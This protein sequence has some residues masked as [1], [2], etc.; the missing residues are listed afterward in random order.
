MNDKIIAVIKREFGRHF[1]NQ[2]QMVNSYEELPK[3]FRRKGIFSRPSWNF[4]SKNGQ[5]FTINIDGNKYLTQL[6]NGKDN[7]FD[8]VGPLE[9][10]DTMGYG[11][12][13]LE[14]ENQL[15]LNYLDLK[16]KDLLKYIATEKTNDSRNITESD[17][18]R[19]VKKIIK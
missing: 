11:V 1:F 13:P 7:L 14:V 18:I 5:F 4:H 9:I 3:E 6:P 10:L 19:L 15:K 2:I 12:E 8:E 17:I 16:L